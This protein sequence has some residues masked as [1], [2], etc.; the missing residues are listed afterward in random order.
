MEDKLL[1]PLDKEA[2]DTL[3]ICLRQFDLELLL[4]TLYEFIE[5]YVKHS[6][7]EELIWP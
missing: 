7:D 1:E 4:G 2:K 5:T 3:E 6:L